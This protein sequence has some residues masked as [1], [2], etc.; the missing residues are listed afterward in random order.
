VGQH[1]APFVEDEVVVQEKVQVE[2]ARRVGKRPHA[3]QFG[4]DRQQAIE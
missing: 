4:L 3:P 2:R 1:Q